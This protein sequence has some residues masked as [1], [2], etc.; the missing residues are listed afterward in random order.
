M[1]RAKFLELVEPEDLL[2]ADRGEEQLMQKEV[3]REDRLKSPPRW[4]DRPRWKGK[5]ESQEW[6]KGKAKRSKKGKEEGKT[7]AEGAAEAK[8]KD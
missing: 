8:K 5:G 6:S 4:G 1:K 3:E 2:S 7:P